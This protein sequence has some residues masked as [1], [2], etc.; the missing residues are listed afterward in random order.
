MQQHATARVIY[1]NTLLPLSPFAFL[2]SHPMNLVL[3][4]MQDA[5]KRFV[6]I[7]A[8]ATVRDGML[9]R[10]GLH[11]RDKDS[12]RSLPGC[13]CRAVRRRAQYMNGEV[14]KHM[15]RHTQNVNVCDN[16]TC[17]KYQVHVHDTI[18]D[19]ILV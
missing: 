12:T 18:R 4:S 7:F 14:E 10:P 11:H 8:R 1:L 15:E 5:F 16:A 3:S 17:T 13:A 19:A 9:G 2:L 6:S